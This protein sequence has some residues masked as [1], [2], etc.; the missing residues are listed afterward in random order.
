MADQHNDN[1]NQPEKVNTRFPGLQA[2]NGVKPENMNVLPGAA[3]QGG[4]GDANNSQQQQAQQQQNSGGDNNNGAAAQ[5]AAAGANANG[6]DNGDQ[7]QPGAKPAG[8][9]VDLDNLSDEDRDKLIEKL[10]KGKVKSL[11]DLDEAPK[12]KSKEEL[13]AEATQRRQDALSWAIDTGKVKREE[14]DEA[15]VMQSKSDRELALSAFTASLQAED[16]DVTPEEA[17]ELFKDVYH[18]G[19]KADGPLYKAGQREIKKLADAVRREKAGI[20]DE[21]EPDF[22]NFT[23][24]QSQFK[25]FKKQVKTIADTAPKTVDFTIPYKNVDGSENNLSYTAQVDPAILNKIVNDLTAENAFVVRNISSNGK[26]NEKALSEELTYH[27]KAR[28][29]DTVIPQL[30][31][32]HGK[33]VE[34]LLVVQLGNKRIGNQNLNNGQQ[35]AGANG[36]KTNTYPGLNDWKAKQKF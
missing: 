11:G 30:L 17:A 18:E 7:Q 13:E 5:A 6:N 10:T 19:Q 29:F 14:Y 31:A 36:T 28:M 12:P 3:G 1:N 23:Q 33:K 9:A 16:E 20:L 8:S 2:A 27:I 22:E 24:T 35:S 34:E 32:D 25:A 26:I 15:I 4:D 21:I